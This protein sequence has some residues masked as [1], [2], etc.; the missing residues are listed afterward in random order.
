MLFLCSATYSRRVNIRVL[1]SRLLLF[2]EAVAAVVVDVGFNKRPGVGRI[3][4]I[5]A[6]SGSA[7]R[8]RQS[9]KSTGAWWVPSLWVALHAREVVWGRF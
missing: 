5:G 2:G 3:Q 9:R 1:I 4:A 8:R 7:R 6:S